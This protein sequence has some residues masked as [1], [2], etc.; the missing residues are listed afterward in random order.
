METSE[1]LRPEPWDWRKA[2]DLRREA[3]ITQR[4]AELILGISA[5]YFSTLERSPEAGGKAP[6]GMVEKWGLTILRGVLD[7]RVAN[8]LPT[9]G[10]GAPDE[11]A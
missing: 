8:P 10:G 4:E 1:K 9:V 6:L 2:A 7:G 5:G 3:G 11:S